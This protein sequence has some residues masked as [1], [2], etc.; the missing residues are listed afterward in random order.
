MPHFERRVA[1]RSTWGYENRFSDVIIKTVFMLG[2]SLHDEI[3]QENINKES[4]KFNDIVQANFIDS[5]F[6]NTIK[7]AMAYR[8]A[9]EYC[10]YSQFYIFMDDDMYAS[11]KNLLSFIRNP[12]YY[13]EYLKR[14]DETLR[15]LVHQRKL[16]TNA[17]ST[18]LNRSKRQLVDYELP[19]DAKLYAG[20]V[21]DTYPLRDFGSKWYISLKE[22]PWN[23]YP[24]YVTAGSVVLS[25]EALHVLYYAFYYV[26]H[27]RFDD[28]FIAIAAYKTGIEPLHNGEFLT[29]HSHFTG[30]NRYT[31]TAHGFG[32]PEK[33]IVAWTDARAAG[34]A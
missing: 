11:T 5:Y 2:I 16:L 24:R 22:Y 9:V 6:N 30:S 20:F 26:K 19:A 23:K 12:V 29:S 34:N 32:D 4:E 17:S 8:W 27:F 3:L 7:T 14:T 1:I 25:N 10:P 33:L 18:D 21:Y 15:M 31:L 13:P 28:I